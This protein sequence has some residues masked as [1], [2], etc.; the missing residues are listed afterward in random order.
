MQPAEA[1]PLPRRWGPALG[2]LLVLAVIL[3]ALAAASTARSPPAAVP[4][5]PTHVRAQPGDGGEIRLAWDAS[6][7][8]ETYLVHRASEDQAFEPVAET[9]AT[10]YVDE[11][12]QTDTTYAYRVLAANEAGQ[13]QRCPVVEATAVPAFPDPALA[14]LALLAGLGL[15]QAASR[16]R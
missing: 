2:L 12:T 6:P 3:P 7:S 1:I 15:V 10:G 4:S 16:H 9:E 5:C 14:G 11:Q 8:A 13:A